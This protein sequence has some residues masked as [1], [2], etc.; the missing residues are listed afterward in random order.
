MKAPNIL[1]KL[2]LASAVGLATSQANALIMD[3]DWVVTAEWTSANFSGGTGSTQVETNILSW[4]QGPVAVPTL[5]PDND[6][7]GLIID[8]TEVEGSLG[9][10]TQVVTNGGTV[11][12][13]LITH[14]NNPISSNFATLQ[15]A[16]LTT[17]LSL[18]PSGG[19]FPD[20]PVEQ[21]IPIRFSETPNVSD[22]GFTST[23]EC[24]DIFEFTLPE[25]LSF[26]FELGNAEYTTTIGA[27]NPGSLGSACGVIGADP[28]CI[29]ILT[30][31]NNSNPV[32]FNFG[33]IGRELPPP[34][35]VPVPA[36]LALFGAGLLGLSGLARRRRAQG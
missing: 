24:D 2:A 22:C 11:D 28:D 8:D 4:G 34:P 1:K 31:E 32:Q 14:I 7:S 35:P 27:P 13:V 17:T 18:T 25:S 26:T 33:I 15:T 10:G 20:D 16:E 12:T 9:D 21:V 5:N 6:R 3:W 19:P 36:T 29:G 23:S 30:Q